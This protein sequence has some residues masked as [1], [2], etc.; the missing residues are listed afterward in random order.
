MTFLKLEYIVIYYNKL[1]YTV[2]FMNQEY[3]QN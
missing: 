2:V 1:Q 3:E